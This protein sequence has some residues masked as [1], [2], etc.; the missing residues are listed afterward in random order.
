MR[1]EPPLSAAFL[2]IHGAAIPLGRSLAFALSE[3]LL[4]INDALVQCNI[5]CAAI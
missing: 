4:G 5:Y 2:V 3:L 1:E